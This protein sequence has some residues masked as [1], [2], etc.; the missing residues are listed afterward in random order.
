[1][2][3]HDK[4]KAIFNGTISRT[5]QDGPLILRHVPTGQV[6]NFLI[7]FRPSGKPLTTH[8]HLSDGQVFIAPSHEFEEVG[9]RRIRS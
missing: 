7:E 4:Y 6:G 5:L 3:L 1:M 8:I 9:L 2:G